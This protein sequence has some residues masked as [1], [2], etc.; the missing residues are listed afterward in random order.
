[1]TH[2]LSQTFVLPLLPD[3]V[4]NILFAHKCDLLTNVTRSQMRLAHMSSC[5]PAQFVLSV[6][7]DISQTL[8]IAQDILQL[9]QLQHVIE[10]VPDQDWVNAM[11]VIIF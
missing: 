2:L 3:T 7:H 9:G 5:I 1:M 10:E 11:K 4:A 6:Q 8:Q